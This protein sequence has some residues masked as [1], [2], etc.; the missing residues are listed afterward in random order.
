MTRKAISIDTAARGCHA[1]GHR[2]L[3]PSTVDGDLASDD[4]LQVLSDGVVL[5]DDEGRIRYVNERAAA[6]TAYSAVVGWLMFGPRGLTSARIALWSLVF[7]VAWLGFTLIHGAFVHWY[8]SPFFD[9]TKLGYGGT[10]LNCLWV[11]RLL[12]GL[13]AGATAVDR[14]L[15]RSHG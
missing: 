11:S 7:P 3:V 12:L 13:A 8:P 15:G 6:L 5:V 10:L 2:Y 1:P 14:R 4:R 9:V